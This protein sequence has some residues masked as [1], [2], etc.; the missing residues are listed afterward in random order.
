MD[1]LKEV[2]AELVKVTWPK[3]G[4]VIKLTIVVIGVSAA[5]GVYL[6]GLDYIFAKMIE[7]LLKK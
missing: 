5:V 1:F 6:G 4:A 2:R 3:R 7:T